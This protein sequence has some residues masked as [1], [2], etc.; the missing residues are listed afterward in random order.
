MKVVVPAVGNVEEDEL[1][2][3][4]IDPVQQLLIFAEITHL[5]TSH[6][7]IVVVVEED[8]VASAC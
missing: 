8:R 7:F 1:N 5:L 6:S 4:G 2:N 3:E